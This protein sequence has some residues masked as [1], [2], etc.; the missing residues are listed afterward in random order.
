M[1]QSLDKYSK[2]PVSK[3]VIQNAL[4]AV[5]AMLM[6]LIYNLADTFFIGQTHDAY[7][8]AAVSLATPVFLVFMSIGTIFGV[9]GT[10]VIS[11]AFGEGK[12]EYAKKV[13]SFCMWSCIAIGVVLTV[14]FLLF[15][16]PLL[17]LIGASAD[18]WEY[19]K[20]YL[21]IVSFSGTFALIS[22]C[23]SN[24]LRAEGQATKAMNGQLIGNLL[25]MLLDAV[26]I[27]VFHWDIVGCALATL[28]GEIAGAAY[29]L[30]Y[31]LTGKSSLSVNI[32]DFTLKDRVAGS[33]FAI[34]IPAALGSLLMSAS[35]IIMN[36]Q[37][38]SYGDMAVAGIGV[39]MKIVMITGMVSMGI[40][41]GVQPLLGYCVG[42][43]TWDR[44]KKYMKFAF[45]FATLL[46]VS[47]TILC[48]LFTNQIV[49]VFLTDANA[50]DYAVKFARILLSTGPVFG[51]FYVI[52]NAL[53]A[54]GAAMPS[55]IINISRQGL[56]YIPVLFLLNAMLGVTGLVWAQPVV[57]VISLVVGIGMYLN[58][59]GKM[60]KQ[61][62]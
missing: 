13:C 27:M 46:G 22:S 7:Q 24:I 36:S 6:V 21:T 31:Y 10:S 32:K 4:P 28:F 15:M 35:Q 60:M 59:S 45:C 29:Y 48:Y 5:A 12:K 34:G 1:E 40:G 42:A 19:T 44:F 9:G 14:C 30:Y 51:I 3:A 18:T 50:F 56:I 49:G 47:L 55:L 25:N 57:D 41:Q 26:L 53:Q 43:K 17:R 20:I 2:M 61:M 16:E 58:V 37:M 62:A 8:V 33:V 38:S 39:A 54:M 11:R 52:T 23:F